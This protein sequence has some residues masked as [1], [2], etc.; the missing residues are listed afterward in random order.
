MACLLRTPVAA[1]SPEGT[2]ADSTQTPAA[3]AGQI[4]L[5]SAD[6][7]GR[8]L[9]CSDD[10]FASMDHLVRAAEPVFDP[11]AY[12]D[13]GKLMDGWESRRKRVPGHDW[14]ILKLGVPG[15]VRGVDIDTAYFMGNHPPYASVEGCNV[16]PGTEVDALRTEVEWTEIVPAMP[17]QRGSHNLQAVAHL[18]VWTHIR[19]RIFPDGGVA[20]LRIW[21]EPQPARDQGVEVDLACIRQ[22]GQALAC[23]D[24]FFS[25]MNNLVLPR[26]AENMGG[27]WETRRSRPP[28]MDWIIVKLGTPGRLSQAVVDTKHFK[29]NFPDTVALD[30]LYWPDA[31]LPALVETD[32]WSEILPRFE[33]TADGNHLKEITDAGPWTHV[34]LR[35]YPDGGVSRL[36]VFG[37]PTDDRPSDARID[38][39]N[40]QSHEEAVATLMRCCGSTRWATRMAAARPFSGWTELHGMAEWLWWQLDDADWSEAF[41]HHPKIGA[42]PAQLREKFAATADWSDSEQAGLAEAD[43]ETISRLAQGN[44]AYDDRFGFIFIVCAS[45]LSAAE[46]LTRLEARLPHKPENEIR[47]A[48]GEQVKITALRLDKLEL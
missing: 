11:D 17:L 23:S 5:A 28:G 20:R 47:I 26:A 33:T 19:L 39:L 10:F 14:C 16:S 38:A 36:R 1:Y 12:T 7:D 43:E 13:T 21:G 15:L 37:V 31:P 27:G 6:L 29:G 41:T 8:T 30:G 35:I 32:A 46:M 25:P 42:D 4:D 3:F 9:A 44:Q 45:G 18:G 40:A 34:R 24:M 48:A 22:G 2:M